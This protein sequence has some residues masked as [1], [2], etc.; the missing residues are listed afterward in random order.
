MSDMPC[1]SAATNRVLSIVALVLVALLSS[2]SSDSGDSTVAFDDQSTSEPA[3]AQP[4]ADADSAESTAV[5]D[6]DTTAAAAEDTDPTQ[7]STTVEATT[8]TTLAPAPEQPDLPQDCLGLDA[9]LLS[10]QTTFSAEERLFGIGFDGQPMCLLFL[11][12]G[13]R[14]VAWSAQADKVVFSD[15]RVEALDAGVDGQAADGLARQHTQ[16]SRPTGFNLVW[17]ADGAVEVSN[18]D[19]GFRRSLPIGFAVSEVDYHPDGK[20]LLVVGADPAFAGDSLWVTNIEGG[21]GR[22]LLYP[23]NGGRIAEVALG[24]DGAQI[25][26]VVESPEGATTLHRF[27]LAGAAREVTLDDGTVDEIVLDPSGG[28]VPELLHESASPLTDLVVGSDGKLMAFAEGTCQGGRAVEVI[29]L[30]AGG[31]PLP[32][33]AGRSGRPVGFISPFEL[34]V[35]VD[36]PD[37]GAQFDLYAV[38]V[39]TGAERLVRARVESA[40]VRR[41]DPPPTFGL[42]NVS[43]LTFAV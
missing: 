6:D 37:C 20:N 43:I 15:G 32:V 17:V 31:Y 12:S 34:L 39:T 25:L 23:Q 21:E 5:A 30:A 1:P 4:D 40:A 2:C 26:F 24:F 3:P 29:D 38:D 28:Y 36:L 27:D 42:N 41:I 19:G 35:A 8:S 18:L 11:D 9:P 10:V 13:S 33:M 22:P 14:V 7:P 16:F